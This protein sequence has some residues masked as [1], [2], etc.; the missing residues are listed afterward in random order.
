SGR[1]GPCKSPPQQVD[2]RRCCDQGSGLSL[3]GDVP[4][5]TIAFAAPP[6]Q[7]DPKAANPSNRRRF[8]FDY[9][10]MPASSVHKWPPAPEDFECL[11]R[12]AFYWLQPCAWL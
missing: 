7:C 2:V 3:R 1:A 10:D 5:V 12:I 11:R 8:S 6:A 9:F 4:K